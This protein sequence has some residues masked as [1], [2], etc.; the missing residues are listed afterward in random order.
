MYVIIQLKA[1]LVDVDSFG[2]IGDNAY[3]SCDA[4]VND[5]VSVVGI[6]YLRLWVHVH[7]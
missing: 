5:N 7:E 2:F 3:L 1:Q 4:I 6:Y